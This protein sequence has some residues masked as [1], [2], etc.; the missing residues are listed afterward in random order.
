MLL[1]GGLNSDGV[2]GQLVSLRKPRTK[3][4]RFACVSAPDLL[5]PLGH[6][7]EKACLG[8]FVSASGRGGGL[9]H[10]LSVAGLR[11]LVQCAVQDTHDTAA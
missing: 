5:G 9:V 3:F 1:H 4:L 10:A 11:L 6:A 8:P 7:Y 2:I